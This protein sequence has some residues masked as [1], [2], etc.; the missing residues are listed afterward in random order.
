MR[1]RTREGTAAHG[2]ARRRT[3]APNAT[4]TRQLTWNCEQPK[5]STAVSGGVLRHMSRV[6]GTPSLSPSAA[7]ATAHGVSSNAPTQQ[8]VTATAR[9]M[10]AA[11]GETRRC[12][13]V[14]LMWRCLCCCGC[15]R[16][17]SG[18]ASGVGLLSVFRGETASYVRRVRVPSAARRRCVSGTPSSF[19][20]RT[21]AAVLGFSALAVL[22]STRRRL[23]PPK[24]VPA[25]ADAPEVVVRVP[26]QLLPRLKNDRLIR[27]ALRQRVD[28]T[29]VWVM[30]QAGRCV[31]GVA[32]GSGP[33]CLHRA[34]SLAPTVH[35][36]RC[37]R[38]VVAAQIPAR[39]QGGSRALGRRL[40]QGAC[41]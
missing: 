35:A 29:P 6:S 10:A 26:L 11:G 31:A 39:V 5:P 3:P 15:C 1:G 27:A 8:R 14:A 37:C 38:C 32:A 17:N 34:R 40:F 21:M 23:L 7:S 2:R 24:D 22:L 16:D 19:S 18:S 9:R 33:V 30:R 20:T 25:A 12:A 13:V 41:R 36:A 28:R 4:P